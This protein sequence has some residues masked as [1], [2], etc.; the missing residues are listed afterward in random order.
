MD[1]I[2]IFGSYTKEQHHAI[3]VQVLDIPHKHQLYLQAMEC[4]FRQPTVE[5]L[6]LILSEG[7][8]EMDTIKLAG[9]CDWL[10]PTSMTE[11]QSFVM[12]VNCYQ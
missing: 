1:N 9:V 7:Q 12:F 10:T 5:F 3:I 4:T 6:G 11:V 8:V 2:L